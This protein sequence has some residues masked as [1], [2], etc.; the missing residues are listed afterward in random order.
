MRRFLSLDL[1]ISLLLI[2]F[3]LFVCEPIAA[4]RQSNP[5][6][7]RS[8]S[9]MGTIQPRM[10]SVAGRVSDAESHTTIDGIRVDLRAFTG[11]TIATAFTSGNGNFQFNNIPAGSYE[12]VV[13]QMGYQGTHQQVDIQGTTF[14]LMIELRPIVRPSNMP[15]GNPIISKRELSIPR[16]AHDAMQKG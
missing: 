15:S 9:G 1:F 10:F 11:G 7:P 2:C 13:E 4:Q 8:T 3:L 12:V 5:N 6:E 16:K 14:G